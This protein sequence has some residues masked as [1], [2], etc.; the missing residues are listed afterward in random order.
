MLTVPNPEPFPGVPRFFRRDFDGLMIYGVSGRSS[1]P[2]DHRHEDE[3]F[4]RLRR[5]PS[6]C[7]SAQETQ[8]EYGS[9][10]LDGVEEISEEEFAAAM[11]RGFVPEAVVTRTTAAERIM[12]G[13]RT[14]PLTPVEEAF[15]GRPDHM[16]KPL[17]CQRTDLGETPDIRVHPQT[18]ERLRKVLMHDARFNGT[19]GNGIG[20]SEFIDRALDALDCEG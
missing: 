4:R 20:Y 17:G 6:Y 19:Y 3:V 15:F 5:F 11:E 12:R 18:R 16:V 10:P 2:E 9:H 7:F 14:Q 13:G 8:G 1:I